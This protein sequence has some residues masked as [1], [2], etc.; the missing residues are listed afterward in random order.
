MA[1]VTFALLCRAFAITTFLL[2]AA[3]T[4]AATTTG[5]AGVA[6]GD[7]LDIGAARVR[8]HGI[9]A[10]EAG[11][12]CERPDGRAWRCDEAA[13]DLLIEFFRWANRRMRDSRG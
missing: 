10:A 5:T 1:T 3:H 4:S 11:Q 9:D 13:T 12:K 8:L 6:D 7:T 2:A